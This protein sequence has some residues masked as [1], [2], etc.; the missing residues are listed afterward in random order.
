MIILGL[1]SNIGD[2]IGH[3]RDA[4]AALAPLL[5]DM[6][7]SRVYETP[8]LLPKDA[9]PEWDIS[10]YN[11]AVSG[12]SSLSPE[13]LLAEV[14]ALEQSLGRQFRGVWGPREIDID[15]LAIEGVMVDSEALSIPHQGLLGRDFALLPFAELAPDWR[16]AEGTAA[17]LC[18]RQQ[19][20]LPLAEEQL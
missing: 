1:G 16:F 5:S 11:L 8:A 14:K 12:E 18:A 3:L 20:H 4:V 10:Y 9:P 13:A 6:R 2:R 15:I 17:E 7:V 19:Y